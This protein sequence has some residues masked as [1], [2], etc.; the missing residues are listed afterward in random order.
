[1]NDLGPL[2]ALLRRIGRR[3]RM[4]R[5]SIGLSG[6]VAGGCLAWLALF[7]LDW[8][9]QLSAVER[10]VAIIATGVALGWAARRFVLPWLLDHETE[11]QLAI[12]LQRRERI[13]T[14][15]VAALQ[16]EA[17]KPGRWGSSELQQ[18]V[19][20]RVAG[21]APSLPLKDDIP[22]RIVGRRALIAGTA[23]ACAAAVLW[24]FPHHARVFLR[25]LMLQPASYP[26]ATRIDEIQVAGQSVQP[27]PAQ[28][29]VRCPR[30]MAVD[31][32]VIVSGRIPSEGL[33]HL[34]AVESRQSSRL[35]LLR[36]GTT[37][38]AFAGS[39]PPLTGDCE[40]RIRI[41]D[42]S[43]GPILLRLVH[44]PEV[45][46]G[47]EIR[48]PDYGGVED[49]PHRWQEGILQLA[50]PEGSWVRPWLLAD[51]P[52]KRV[53]LRLGDDVLTL[54]P[55]AA[56]PSATD[57]RAAAGPQNAHYGREHGEEIW[58]QGQYWMAEPAATPLA[59][60][61]EP[62]RL[63]FTAEDRDGSAPLKIQALVRPRPDQPP[64]ILAECRVSLVLP[65]AR[66][67]IFCRASD[68]RG[69]ERIDARA[70]RVGA[71][72][73]AE[74]LHTWT[75]WKEDR[76]ATRELEERFPLDL[77][78]TGARKGDRLQVYLL[79]VEQGR[80]GQQ[81]RSVESTPITFEVTDEQGILA[82][83]AELDRKSA[84]QLQQMIDRQLEVGGS[85]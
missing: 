55:A 45:R 65:R 4:L 28:A 15:L 57:G 81:G 17:A 50:V 51:R 77:S 46:L 56:P 78:V 68:D 33:V 16:F 37:P 47:F 75:L 76:R 60:V 24:I 71:D 5:W 49:R 7:A 34:S 82:A 59:E 22:R 52:L 83:M 25:R 26:T 27:R 53:V 14:D 80:D 35:P 64:R 62:I 20:D 69:L 6:V 70:E 36:E 2:H 72:G 21:L 39:L 79:A 54:R 41:G 10:A 66:P 8:G 31:F 61:T 84:D 19:I 74:T 43:V 73:T 30:G 12:L 29:E 18:A 23:V 44:P 67:T 11:L 13:D 48:E 1:M 63:E 38:A 3:R 32:R 40:C 58:T 9:L 85:P 42:A